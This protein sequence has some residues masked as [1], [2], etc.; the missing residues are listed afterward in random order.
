MY[1]M[2]KFIHSFIQIRFEGLVMVELEHWV[3][4]HSHL[5]TT[6]REEYAELH[7]DITLLSGQNWEPWDLCVVQLHFVLRISQFAKK[8]VSEFQISYGVYSRSV[9]LG[10]PGI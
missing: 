9:L 1:F 6:P 2:Y 7:T 10:I 5:G 4:T 8:P 3:H